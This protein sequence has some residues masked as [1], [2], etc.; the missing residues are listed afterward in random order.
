MQWS[1]EYGNRVGS[2]QDTAAFENLSRCVAWIGGGWA[3]R[4][5]QPGEFRHDA[6]RQRVAVRRA[7]ASQRESPLP[8][9]LLQL[10]LPCHAII[11]QSTC[12]H[13]FSAF[14]PLP[15]HPPEGCKIG[16]PR[17]CPVLFQFPAAARRSR[18]VQHHGTEAGNFGV[19]KAQTDDSGVR[20]P[21]ALSPEYTK[22]SL[23]SL[24]QVLW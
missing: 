16:T 10:P 3:H 11:T 5:Q 14:T 13:V 7:D 12:T 8:L 18:I 2:K 4:P 17:V 15:I 20:T 21:A 24:Q 19:C 6:R 9:P 22:Q 23:S 1:S